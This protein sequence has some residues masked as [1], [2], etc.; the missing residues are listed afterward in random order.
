MKHTI[1]VF[2]VTIVPLS[3]ASFLPHL[4][5]TFAAEAVSPR[6]DEWQCARGV[7]ICNRFNID[8]DCVIHS[9]FVAY[10]ARLLHGVEGEGEEGEVG[11]EGRTPLV[12]T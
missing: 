12:A 1:R 9:G 5:I 8:G 10:L 4:P 6:Q 3:V 7:P 2:I 11:G